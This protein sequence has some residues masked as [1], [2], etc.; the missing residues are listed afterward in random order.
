M[1]GRFSI[2]GED[3]NCDEYSIVAAPQRDYVAGRTT[4]PA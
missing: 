2:N 1:S 3:E 4:M